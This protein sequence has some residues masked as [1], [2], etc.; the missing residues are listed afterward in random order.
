MSPVRGP[1]PWRRAGSLAVLATIV[2]AGCY[3]QRVPPQPISEAFHEA[4]LATAWETKVGNGFSRPIV[5]RHGVLYAGSLDRRVVALRLDS[6]KELWSKRLP[7]AVVG[8][9][10][11]SGDTVYV[12]TDR[13]TGRV[14]AMKAT[15]GGKIWQVS[16]GRVTAPI[17]VLD[18][19]LLA[20]TLDGVVVGIRAW[21][22]AVR[23]R[24][25]I[26]GMMVRAVASDSG[27]A[28]VATAD[29]LYRLS[30]GDGKVLT[31]GAAPGPITDDWAEAGTDV[32]AGTATGSVVRID[33]RTLRVVWEVATDAAVLN[34]PAIRGD[35]VFAVT[36][37]GTIYRIDPGPSPAPR[38]ITRLQ[39]PVTAP[40]TPYGPLLL[41]GGADGI[42]R[43]LDHDGREAWR[44]AVWRPIRVPPVV[45][46]DGLLAIGGIGDL[47]RMTAE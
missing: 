35:T 26:G 2:N 15:D 16:A 44:M 23:W 32:I 4:P 40:L 37:L 7:G 42:L 33:R 25:R 8:G 9:V 43:A 11:V 38:I 1:V 46:E 47:R 28:L 3:V 18:G 45:L 19:M 30:T 14:F 6:G 34:S 20:P 36:R 10:T 22:G 5:V 12:G 39:W 41:V 13:P 21:D 29:S 27:V 17:A 31:R 24:R